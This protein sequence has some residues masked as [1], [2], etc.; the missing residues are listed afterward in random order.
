MALPRSLRAIPLLLVCHAAVGQVPV[1]P[2]TPATYET[3]STRETI[4]FG[5]RAPQV[6]DQ[7]EQNVEVELSLRTTT[8]Q[9]TEVL[10]RGEERL[11]SI[12]QRLITAD[13]IENGCTQAAHVKFLVA[14][15]QRNDEPKAARPVT[16]KTYY[17]ER[18][19][20]QLVIRTENGTTPSMEEYR[21]V[22]PCMEML[23]RPNPLASFFAGKTIAV[24][25]TIKL[26]EEIARELLGADEK[27]G[28]VSRFEMKLLRR[29]QVESHDC[30]VFEAEIE[31][32]GAGTTQMR[33]LVTGPIVLE[34][35]TCRAL[36]A[37]FNGPIG[38]SEVQNLY[39]KQYQLD[40]LG[41]FRVA[42]KSMYDLQATR[43]VR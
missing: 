15:K 33:M 21:L 37:D 26:P 8:R 28:K 29:E 6:G 4:T 17:C 34:I 30:G 39:G 38:M 31:A 35:A 5:R 3:P 27:F 23:G 10:E 22:T 14:E 18:K 19:G 9:G 40:S 24:G 13:R 43:G 20:E 1:P 16:G 36:S 12:Q 7:V 2:A 11:T 32:T 41:K 42:V 25:E